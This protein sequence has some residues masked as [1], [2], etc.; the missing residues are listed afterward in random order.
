MIT[1]TERPLK[2]YRRH[3]SLCASKLVAPTY[4]PMTKAAEKADTCTCPI[5]ASG[6]AKGELLRHYS[7][8][9]KDWAEAVQVAVMVKRDGAAPRSIRLV[10]EPKPVAVNNT[11]KA[12][13]TKFEASKGIGSL[14]KIADST[15]DMYRV[16][17]R[18]RLLPW[19]EAQGITEMTAFES[20]VTCMEFVKSWRKLV[21]GEGKELSQASKKNSVHLFQSFLTFAEKH[22]YM[23]D[24]GATGKAFK[25][26]VPE[27]DRSGFELSQYVAILKAFPA[28]AVK[29]GWSET[30]TKQ[31]Y[32]ALE[33][34][35]YTGMR[36]SD[37]AKFNKSEVV[38]SPS[39]KINAVFIQEKLKNTVPNPW[40]TS[41]IPAHVVALLNALPV[42]KDGYFFML[43]DKSGQ[44]DRPAM[45][46]SPGVI[47]DNLQP[48]IDQVTGCPKD[49]DGDRIYVMHSLRH[50]FAIQH[51]RLRKARIETI[52][53]WLGHTNVATTQ[54]HYSRVLD[55]MRLDDERT[56]E[57]STNL[58]LA[59][60][61]AA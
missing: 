3:T 1:M 19:C 59:E 16:L 40:C 24:H 21:R 5:V 36:I 49:A 14:K 7:L 23:G 15:E 35:R 58:M 22:K 11:V 47:S 29:R 13:I 46:I 33:L 60:M 38:A 9:T 32:A 8:D 34:M 26:V 2:L 44:I 53:K 10:E 12:A 30:E 48:L 52:S 45:R 28:Y 31:Y 51:I 61:A 50:T 20:E 37:C 25:V 56:A 57:E 18:E 6:R 17:L 27:P 55:S 41:P 43:P 42:G 39:G 4:Q 54:K